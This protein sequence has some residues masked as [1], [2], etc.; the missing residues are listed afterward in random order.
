MFKRNRR[1][2]LFIDKWYFM[3]LNENKNSVMMA[4]VIVMKE[5]E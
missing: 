3:K 5:I 1:K 4:Q 2:L